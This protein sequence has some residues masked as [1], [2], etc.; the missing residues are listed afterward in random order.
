MTRV[1]DDSI[2]GKLARQQHD[3][4]R[5]VKEGSLPPEKVFLLHKQMLG[6]LLVFVDAS[7]GWV[8]MV[9]GGGYD[10]K[11]ISAKFTEA[12]LPPFYAVDRVNIEVNLRQRSGITSTQEWFNILDDDKSSKERFA[13]PFLVLAIG[14]REKFSDGQFNDPIFTIWKSPSTGQL[15]SL[16]ISED[17]TSRKLSVIT[18]HSKVGWLGFACA[19]AVDKKSGLF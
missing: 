12:D 18:E 1:K 15:W 5:R 13:H 16:C 9:E 7:R 4:F 2:L 17:I 3:I 8:A 19:A 6:N 10:E 14:E 11:H